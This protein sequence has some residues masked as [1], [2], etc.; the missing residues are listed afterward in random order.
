[1]AFGDK[2]DRPVGLTAVILARRGMVMG[3][4][5]L[6]QAPELDGVGKL[7]DIAHIIGDSLPPT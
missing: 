3:N 4:R 2:M 7:P 5:L 1:M 6:E